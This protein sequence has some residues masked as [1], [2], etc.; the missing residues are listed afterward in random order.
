MFITPRS[1]GLVEFLVVVRLLGF[2]GGHYFEGKRS[3]AADSISAKSLR[4]Q[5]W[6]RCRSSKQKEGC[7]VGAAIVRFSAF[8]A[9]TSQSCIR[10]IL[11][12]RPPSLVAILT[13]TSL[14]SNIAKLSLWAALRTT[15]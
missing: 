13:L 10:V 6:T 8:S 12:S 15:T 14:D 5:I 7:F 3:S 11:I 4:C 9:S 2:W 1:N